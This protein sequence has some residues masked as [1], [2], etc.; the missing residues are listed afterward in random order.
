LDATQSSWPQGDQTE[1]AGIANNSR[2]EK[3]GDACSRVGKSAIGCG[4]I[5]PQ[6]VIHPH[7]SQFQQIGVEFCRSLALPKQ[8]PACSAELDAW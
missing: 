4:E 7:L 5:A 3:G 1:S 6:I 8:K 2:L